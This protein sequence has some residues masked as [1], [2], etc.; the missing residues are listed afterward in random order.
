MCRGVL[1]T[2]VNSDSRTVLLRGGGRWSIVLARV[3]TDVLVDG[4]RFI[5]VAGK[6]THAA[7][8][9]AEGVTGARPGLELTV[10][11]ALAE[12]DGWPELDLAIVASATPQHEVDVAAIVRLCSPKRVLVEKPMASNPEAA[13]RMIEI[14]KA[15]VELFV[16]YEFRATSYIQQ[17]AAL[18]ARD[19]VLEMEASW[20]DPAEEQ[21]GGAAKSANW[22]TH[23]ALDQ[24]SH[25]WS[26]VDLFLPG[27]RVTSATPKFHIDGRGLTIDCE[28]EANS[29]P[30][31]NLTLTISRNAYRRERRLTA[32]TRRD[33]KLAI[34]Y[35]VEPGTIT[36]NDEVLSTREEW[37]SAERPLA[38]SIRALLDLTLPDDTLGAEALRELL[39]ASRC[40]DAMEF[41]E[42]IRRCIDLEAKALLLTASGLQRNLA[43]E[44]LLTPHHATSSFDRPDDATLERSAQKF[45]RGE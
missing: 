19:D 40:A 1:V 45:I 4:S 15:P 32:R 35:A 2:A 20:C 10:C 5:W 28:L 39:S 27:V 36:V 14:C 9:F 18:C 42:Y 6:G 23:I 22:A 34:D 24:A 33:R 21:R 41:A 26:I 29:R 8:R 11:E 3:L 12:V 16:N 31:A 44:V 25:I 13:A 43:R 17:F 7:R 38:R 30:S 37:Q